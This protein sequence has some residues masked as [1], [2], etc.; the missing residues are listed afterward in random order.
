M[1]YTGEGKKGYGLLVCSYSGCQQPFL[2]LLKSFRK[3][4]KDGQGSYYC[5]NSCYGKSNAFTIRDGL[6]VCSNPHCQKPFFKD[7]VALKNKL[8]NGYGYF[9]CKPKCLIDSKRNNINSI[10]DKILHNTIKDSNG[11][12]NWVDSRRYGAT[13]LNKKVISTHVLSYRIFNNLDKIP[14][15]LVVRHKCDN[16]KCCNPDHL[17]LG[18]HYDNAQDRVTRNRSAIGMKSGNAKFTDDDIRAIRYLYSLNTKGERK[19]IVK[20]A[21]LAKIYGVHRCTIEKI[22]RNGC[23]THVI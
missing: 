7:I 8:R 6:L 14:H 9:Y 17:E 5:S 22:V 15:G 18:T 4:L 23:W 13:C 19:K 12:W 21:T 11:C 20:C 3:K 2:I 1:E 10:K 16:P